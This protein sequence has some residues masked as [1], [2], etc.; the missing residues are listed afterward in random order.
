MKSIRQSIVIE[1][2]RSRVFELVDDPASYPQFFVGMT[3]WELRS[4]KRRG[5]GAKYRVL[6]QVGSI[7][8]GGTV[9]VTRRRANESIEW[10]YEQG[11]HQEG[12]WTLRSVEGGTE[13]TLEVRYDL[14]GG[15]VGRLVEHLTGRIV[16]RNLWAT[17]LAARRLL[18]TER[19]PA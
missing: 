15:A 10:R 12:R 16:E 3:K 18:E 1:A 13:L 8:A 9:V 14:S 6:M 19:A 4:K 5:P 17:L 7:E 2:P 11:I